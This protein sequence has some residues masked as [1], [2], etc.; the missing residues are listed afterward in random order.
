[1]APTGG[2]WNSWKVLSRA[3]GCNYGSGVFYCLL[4]HNNTMDF[5][6][7]YCPE[8][9]FSKFRCRIFKTLQENTLISRSAAIA[10]KLQNLGSWC[11]LVEG[12]TGSTRQVL[13]VE[14]FSTTPPTTTAT[15]YESFELRMA[16]EPNRSKTLQN[17]HRL[18]SK[19]KF[20]SKRLF[21]K[22]YTV[23][24]ESNLEA[25]R[26]SSH[27]GEHVEIVHAEKRR[28]MREA[29]PGTIE[30]ENRQNWSWWKGWK[31]DPKVI[32]TRKAERMKRRYTLLENL[33]EPVG[34]SPGVPQPFSPLEDGQISS[35]RYELGNRLMRFHRWSVAGGGWWAEVGET[36]ESQK[37]WQ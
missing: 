28:A 4:F 6:A 25:I 35:E 26:T 1:M 36:G 12:I 10:S 11:S 27:D 8:A 37:T 13:I 29:K 30:W 16:V 24:A 23:R 19:L 18:L 31:A 21:L 20:F 33:G 17:H 15:D 2:K 32:A 14:S 5:I 3:P 34:T 7:G 9:I 22:D